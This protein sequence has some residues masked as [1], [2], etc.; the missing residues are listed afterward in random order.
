MDIEVDVP[1]LKREFKT[2]NVRYLEHEE[3]MWNGV[4]IFGT[5]YSP[6][7]RDWA[8]PTVRGVWVGVRALY[9]IVSHE[10][11]YAVLVEVWNSSH[12]GCEQLLT[13]IEQ[14]KPALCVCGHVHEAR[15]VKRVGQTICV[16]ASFVDRRYRVY[17]EPLFYVDLTHGRYSPE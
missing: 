9:V 1:A 17:D 4:R 13:V 16:N 7:F 10:P 11:P 12:A 8:F 15:G 2:D 6:P 14:V 5:P 3:V